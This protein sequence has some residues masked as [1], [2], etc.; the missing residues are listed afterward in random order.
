LSRCGDFSL[1]V[2]GLIRSDKQ[3]ST[4]P[5]AVG[6]KADYP[7]WLELHRLIR[8]L[9]AQICLICSDLRP[10]AVNLLCEGGILIKRLFADSWHNGHS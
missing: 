4:E 10:K 8:F 5:S 2:A 7:D 9:S 6:Y 1:F 3:L